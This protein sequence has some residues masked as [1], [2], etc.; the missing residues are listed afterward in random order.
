MAAAPVL[1][2]Y[3]VIFPAVC[4]VAVGLLAAS[5][6]SFAVGA[7]LGGAICAVLAV[8]DLLRVG[9]LARIGRGRWEAKVSRRLA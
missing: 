3:W 8:L 9:Y 4:I 6:F 1:L 7:P 2:R 5:C